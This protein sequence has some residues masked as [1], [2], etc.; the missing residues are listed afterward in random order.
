[1]TPQPLALI[2]AATLA[3]AALGAA[4]GAAEP[5][6][7]SRAVQLIMDDGVR[8]FFETAGSAGLFE[9]EAGKLAQQ[10]GTSPEVKVF[11]AK[12]VA[13][14]GK[15]A[16]ELAKIAGDK[17]AQLPKAMLKRHQ[18]MLDDLKD[19]TPGQ[20]FDGKYRRYMIAS[21]K[22]VVS[23]FDE[24]GRKSAD[25]DVRAFANRTLPTLQHHGA[26]AHALPK[27]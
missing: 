12:M 1:M 21:H 22:E 13:D 2:R 17:G 9:I 18:K 25:E 4:A 14:H 3:A 26:M 15:A 5:M 6:K 7:P 10:V 23:L 20:A 8:D 16:D 19:E 11:A 24:A 27:Q